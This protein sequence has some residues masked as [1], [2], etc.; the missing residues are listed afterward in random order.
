MKAPTEDQILQLRSAWWRLNNLYH[1][2]PKNKPVCHFKPNWAQVE[3][4]RAKND[5]KARRMCVPKGRQFGISTG[6]VIL[7]LDD[8]LFRRG[9]NISSGIIDITLDQGKDKVAMAKFAYDYLDS[10]NHPHRELGNFIKQGIPLASDNQTTLRWRNG[11]ALHTAM[12]F[13]GKTLKRLHVSDAGK[14]AFNDPE[15][16]N[17]ILESFE[18]V[19]LEAEVMC[20]GVHYGGKSGW[21]YEICKGALNTPPTGDIDPTQ[22]KLVFL[23]WY[24]HPEYTL[25]EEACEKFELKPPMASYFDHLEKNHGIV[26]TLGQKLW[27]SSRCD[28]GGGRNAVYGQYPSTLAESWAAPVEGAIY[29][30]IITDL[31]TKGKVCE[32]EPHADL[33]LFTA[34]DLGH[35]DSTAIWLFQMA[36]QEILWLNWL[37]ESGHPASVYADRIRSWEKLYGRQ[38]S[39]HL[40]PHDGN[41]KNF[42]SGLSPIE[43]LQRAGLPSHSIQ[44]VPRTNNPWDGINRGRELLRRSV[45][46]LE[47]D[48][49]RIVESKEVPSALNRL[50]SYHKKV[51]EFGGT[52]HELPVHDG[53]SHVAD[54]YRTF[55]ESEIKGMI[56]NG[57]WKWAEE[58]KKRNKVKVGMRFSN[59]R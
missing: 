24:K 39:S 17:E 8:C 25:S 11:S 46:H 33:P 6:E 34:W 14:I 10:P 47:C 38:I 49:P 1:I 5:Q 20:E 58:G 43:A 50:E 13:V 32:F 36:P 22:W 41:R 45:F 18:S 59:K 19:P 48:R 53:N 57:P 31:R 44:C 29:G 26:C 12:S 40:L 16:S 27:Y 23:E 7:A 37:E 21:F 15:R 3:L 55:A 42:S 28:Q 51:T 2:R 52:Q 4:M 9:G 35:F 54:A 30:D 56:Q